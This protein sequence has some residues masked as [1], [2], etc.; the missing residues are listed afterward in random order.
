M[1][2]ACATGS[3]GGERALVSGAE[4][5]GLASSS[6]RASAND[7]ARRAQEVGRLLLG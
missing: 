1:R 3:P 2:A 5:A 6:A 7:A 4:I